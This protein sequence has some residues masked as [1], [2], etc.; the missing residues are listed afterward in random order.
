MDIA[1]LSQECKDI[2]EVSADYVTKLLQ[3]LKAK[4]TEIASLNHLDRIRTLA[5]MIPH[6]TTMPNLPQTYRLFMPEKTLIV[7][8]NSISDL[9]PECLKSEWI[10]AGDHVLGMNCIMLHPNKNK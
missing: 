7:L 10:D 5:Q 1:T 3:Y 6:S 8:F 4:P 2:E 9:F